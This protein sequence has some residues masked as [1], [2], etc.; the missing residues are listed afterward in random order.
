MVLLYFLFYF[1]G[2]SILEVVDIESF[3]KSST[4]SQTQWPV[5]SPIDYLIY[6][7]LQTK[8]ILGQNCFFACKLIRRLL[9]CLYQWNDC[10]WRVSLLIAK[11]VMMLTSP[12]ERPRGGKYQRS[13]HCAVPKSA[14]FECSIRLDTRCPWPYHGI[15]SV[16]AYERWCNPANC[17]THSIRSIG[18]NQLV[19][20]TA[21]AVWMYQSLIELLQTKTN[22]DII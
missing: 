9:L 11:L 15:H 10:V 18:T 16:P 2:C 12:E 20:S 22:S 19:F 17:M 13:S 8:T 7:P 5:N 14:R 4:E 6:N 1:I 21:T 3:K